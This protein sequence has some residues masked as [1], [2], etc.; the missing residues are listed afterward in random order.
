MHEQATELGV[1][2]DLSGAS[3]SWVRHKEIQVYIETTKIKRNLF[4]LYNTFTFAEHFR[5]VF[6]LSSRYPRKK[7][8]SIHPLNKQV[9][10]G[11]SQCE[12][13]PDVSLESKSALAAVTTHHGLR[14]L[15]KRHYSPRFWSLVVQD[16]GADRFRVWRGPTSWFIDGCLYPITWWKGHT[17]SLGISLNHESSTLMT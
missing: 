11:K 6:H 4:L 9:G 13:G 8:R 2:Q 5:S 14:G 3:R 12:L 7:G 16:E 15:N 17:D 1:R 10:K